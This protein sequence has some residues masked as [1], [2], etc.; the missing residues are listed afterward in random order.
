MGDAFV[1]QDG[2]SYEVGQIVSATDLRL[3][4]P[5]QGAG[6]G[7]QAYAI[8]PTQSFAH[9]LALAAAALLNTFSAVRDG[10]GQ[11]LF[12]D[13]TAAAPG[14]RFTADQDTGIRRV[15][16]N[17]IALVTG[18]QDILTAGTYVGIGTGNP[19]HKL[20]VNNSNTD[21]TFALVGNNTNGIGIGIRGDGMPAILSFFSPGIA[22]GGGLGGGL[23]EYGRFDGSGNLGL[24][25]T[26]PRGKVEAF[27]NVAGVS[28]IVISSSFS[29]ASYVELNAGVNGVSNGG[30][31]IR[32]GGVSRAVIDDAGNLLVGATSASNHVVAR[33]TSEGDLIM[34]V[35]GKAHPG[36]AFFSAA[37]G[38]ANGAACA[39]ALNKNS[40]T[41]RSANAAGTINAAGADSAEYMVKAAGCGIIAKGDVCGVDSEGKLTKTWADAISFV[42]K[43]TDPHLVG[44]DTWAAHLPPRPVAPGAE[45]VAPIEPGAAPVAPVEPGPEPAEEGPAYVAWLEARFA[46]A[47]AERDYAVTLAEWQAAT[48]A[49]PAARA[50][51]EADH[52]EWVAAKAAYS[53]DLPEW[54]ADL[55]AARVCVDRIAFCGQV[56]CN[57]TG[58]F[59]V[60]DYIIAAQDGAGIKAVAMKLDDMTMAQYARRIG[61]VWAIRDGRAWID[62]QHG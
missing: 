54:E 13:G 29:P 57:V 56:P 50:S 2:R 27:R 30:F 18:G 51:Y 24:G 1:G 62:V 22:F 14:F 40:A 46:F 44:G 55:E 25:T 12:G 32:L 52:A 33:G 4:T 19:L 34:Q 26:T 58:E 3:T 20:H 17:V 60:G 11:G 7:G 36:V 31:D 5:Y 23:T 28:N 38:S 53:H 41:G 47:V 16:S 9:D 39:F 42:V 59:D 43:S 45:P 10:V 49:Y 21:P 48:D 61:K 8:Q 37:S 15:A 35:Q 6:G